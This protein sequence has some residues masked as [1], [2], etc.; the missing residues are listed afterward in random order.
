M[1]ID[2]ELRIQRREFISKEATVVQRQV[3]VLLSTLSVT[4]IQREEEI[5]KT[6]HSLSN[7]IAL[8]LSFF[9]IDSVCD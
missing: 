7:S 5:N 1:E 3:K 2:F 8:M 6:R 9:I 4:L